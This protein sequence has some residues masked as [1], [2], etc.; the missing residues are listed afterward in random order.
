MADIFSLSAMLGS[1]TGVTTML[2]GLVLLILVHEAGHWLVARYYGFKTPVFSIG[3]G[4]R[5][6]SW[7]LG[8]FWETEFRITPFLLG[9]YVS[10][11]ELQDESTMLELQKQSGGDASKVQYK[12]FPVYQ[13]MLV[14]IA[15][16]VMNVLTALVIF[17]ALFFFVGKMTATPTTQ[18]A[19]FGEQVTIARDAGVQVKDVIVTVN[20]VKTDSPQQIMQTLQTRK[21]LV[22]PI[23]VNRNGSPIEVLVT[24]NDK[25][26]VGIAFAIK[27]EANKLSFGSAL[28]ESGKTTYEAIGGM[29]HGLGMMVGLVEKPQGAEMR[30]I[31]GIVQMGSDAYSMGWYQFNWLLAMISLNLAVMNI[32]PI[33]A[34]DGGHMLFFTIEGLRGKPVNPALKGRV[35]LLFV[36]MLM[37]LFVYMTGADLLRIFGI[38]F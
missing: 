7:V 34:L 5:N 8:T 18:V 26:Q 32:L 35:T 33:P 11:P 9:G 12:V 20:G 4:T 19:G 36:A 3:F 15:G 24:P 14:A 21:N 16:I 23:G 13:R 29:F 10:I 27:V 17:A 2:L 38:S 6:M 28:V 25:G 31:I 1:M 37:L 30:G 22:T